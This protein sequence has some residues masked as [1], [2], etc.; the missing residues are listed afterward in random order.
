MRTIQLLS[1]VFLLHVA[2]TAQPPAASPT[3][4]PTETPQVKPLDVKMDEPPIVTHHSVR[5]G[6]KQLLYTV[7]TGFMPLK[8][9]VSGDIEARIFY[10]AYTLDNPPANRPLMFS[11]N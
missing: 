8:N 11:F 6:G 2:A 4:K 9:A 10:M 3:P 7:T 1:L 5:A